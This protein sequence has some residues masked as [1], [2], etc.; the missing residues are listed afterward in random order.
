MV[1]LLRR[2]FVSLES[3]HDLQGKMNCLYVSILVI[4]PD[5]LRV[6]PMTSPPTVFVWLFVI[7]SAEAAF[8]RAFGGRSSKRNLRKIILIIYQTIAV[9][10]IR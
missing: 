7:Y 6:F 9:H 3:N 4:Y 10:W 1:P 2:E 8:I 5:K